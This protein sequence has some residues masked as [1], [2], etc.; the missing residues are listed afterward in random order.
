MYVFQLTARGQA[1]ESF[2]FLD[3]GRK[4]IVKSFAALTTPQMHRVWKRKG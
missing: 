2:E 3:L 4:W 1:G